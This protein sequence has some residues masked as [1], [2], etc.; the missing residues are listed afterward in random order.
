M[1]ALVSKPARPGGRAEPADHGFP[2]GGLR[3]PKRICRLSMLDDRE[4]QRLWRGALAL[5]VG[6]GDLECVFAGLEFGG[7]GDAPGKLGLVGALT[8]AEGEAARD[9]RA[10][11]VRLA[12]GLV[13]R[14]DALAI[15]FASGGLL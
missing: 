9:G 12:A 3:R 7:L 2:C 14:R 5:G 13:G 1:K 8:A 4:R 15:N 6:G 10:L 11:A